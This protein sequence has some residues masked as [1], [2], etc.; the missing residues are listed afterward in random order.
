MTEK[1]L[2]WLAPSE[3]QGTRDF[4]RSVHDLVR[5]SP[6]PFIATAIPM[7]QSGI[8]TMLHVVAGTVDGDLVQFSDSTIREFETIAAET[9]ARL[10]EEELKA[11]QRALDS[12]EIGGLSGASGDELAVVASTASVRRLQERIATLVTRTR[13]E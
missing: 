2:A 12:R 6:G 11:A 1:R 5:A 7:G 4:L 8:L 10:S 13:P 3:G 9:I